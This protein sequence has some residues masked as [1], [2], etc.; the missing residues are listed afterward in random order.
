MLRPAAPKLAAMEAAPDAGPAPT[1][2]EPAYS[3]TTWSFSA[4]MMQTTSSISF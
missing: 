1:P 2:G 4:T 3:K